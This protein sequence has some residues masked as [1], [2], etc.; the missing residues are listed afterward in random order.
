[1]QATLGKKTHGMQGK[2][3]PVATTFQHISAQDLKH[4]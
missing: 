3:G 4:F 1:M 2:I